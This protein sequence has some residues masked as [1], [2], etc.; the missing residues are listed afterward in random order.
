MTQ[1]TKDDWRTITA[2]EGARRSLKDS[3]RGSWIAMHLTPGYLGRYGQYPCHISD[4]V[5][6]RHT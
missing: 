3:L 2:N 4:P 5:G 1:L 6:N